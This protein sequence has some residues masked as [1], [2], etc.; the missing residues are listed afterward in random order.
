MEEPDEDGAMQKCMTDVESTECYLNNFRARKVHGFE[1]NNHV[2]PC[3]IRC[4]QRLVANRVLI[5]TQNGNVKHAGG[6]MGRKSVSRLSQGQGFH[7]EFH[8]CH[9]SA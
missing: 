7:R 5:L 9:D 6:R 2:I 8:S 4:E 3:D 1:F